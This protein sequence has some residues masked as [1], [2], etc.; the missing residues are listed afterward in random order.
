MTKYNLGRLI[1]DVDITRCLGLNVTL[2]ACR[3]L[4]L[5]LVIG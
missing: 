5:E 2:S 3:P 1:F 4:P